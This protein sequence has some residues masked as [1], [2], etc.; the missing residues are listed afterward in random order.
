MLRASLRYFNVDTDLRSVL[1]TSTDA[2]VG[3]STVAW[4]LARIAASSSR[5]R[6]SSRPT[7][8]I[9]SLARQHGLAA[10]PGLAELLTHQVDLDE[11][12]QKKTLAVRGRRNGG[13]RPPPRRDRRRRRPAQSGRADRKPGD[14][15]GA[16][17]AQPRLRL[18]RRSTPRR[19]ASS[20]TPSRCLQQVD[21]VI[22]VARMGQHARGTTRTT[23]REQLDQMKA[24]APRDRR[25][26]RQAPQTRP[27]PTA[28]TAPARLERGNGPAPRRRPRQR[29]CTEGL[30]RRSPA[31]AHPL[32]AEGPDAG[33]AI[34]GDR[35]QQRAEAGVG[36]DQDPP[37][38]R[39]D[40]ARRAAPPASSARRR[41]PRKAGRGSGRSRS[42]RSAIA[43][44][45]AGSSAGRVGSR[46]CRSIIGTAGIGGSA[47]SP[48]GRRRAPAMALP[49]FACRRER[50]TQERHSS[51]SR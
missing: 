42:R 51:G 3:K 19:S 10:A 4:N 16:R 27:T 44:S 8:A 15:R 33:Q 21:G 47:S 50:T 45:Q 34:G 32:R 18:R 22:A 20:P 31:S 5:R 11:A 29:A 30:G 6:S 23:C 2:G 7:C 43:A 17:P 24:P 40:A 49:S 12:I 39:R 41:S 14:E 46:S 38:A 37:A 13:G 25:E 35:E 26:R 48:F 9:P 36:R 1:V 28:T